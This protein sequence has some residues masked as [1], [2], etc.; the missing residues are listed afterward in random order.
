MISA[1]FWSVLVVLSVLSAASAIRYFPNDAVWFEDV[2]N[3]TLDSESK[4]IIDWLTERGGWGGN[5]QF[6]VDQVFHILYA[7]Q[8]TPRATIE[9]HPK[10]YVPD[11][12]TEITEMP[13]PTN[14]AI[15]GSSD[16]SCDW[17]N[18]DC[19]LIVVDNYRGLIF[20]TYQTNVAD[21]KIQ[22]SCLIV[23]DM[24]TT[25]PANGRGEQCT[26]ADAAGFPISQL[27]L[28]PDE[29][30]TGEIDHA[31]RFILPNWR[32]RAETYVHPASHAGAPN[33]TGTAPIYG[34][35]FRLK[36]SF[37]DSSFSDSAK[38]VI[39][40][41]KKYGMF[42]SDGGNIPFSAMSDQFTTNKWEALGFDS[43]SLWGIEASDFEVI[44]G[45]NRI[46]LTFL[47]SV[48]GAPS[49][50]SNSPQGNAPT[51]PQTNPVPSTAPQGGSNS[52][53]TPSNT[54]SAKTS[55]AASSLVH[56][57]LLLTMIIAFVF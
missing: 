33:A 14:G 1:K 54:P 24:C 25:Y 8:N 11:C 5:G 13:L 20:E 35:R 19:H 37:D 22:T 56:G 21:G 18:N 44:D 3:A 10:Y 43:H 30:A 39:R 12:E 6:Q 27:L 26:S 29:I 2:T 38:V 36:D 34:N 57:S 42:L 28:N 40:A 7:D 15:E 23:W 47:L 17:E 9:R 55:S 52:T 51:S 32:M 16:Y 49:F 41:L 46:A 31:F 4:Q 53:P 50:I 45:G 48:N